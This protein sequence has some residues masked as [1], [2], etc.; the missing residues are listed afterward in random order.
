MNIRDIAQLANVSIS[1]VSKV[2][3]KKDESISAETREKILRIIK[4]YNYSPYANVRTPVKG[5]TLVLGVLINSASMQSS[6]IMGILRQSHEQG[7]GTLLYVSST[8][9]EEARNIHLLSSHNVDGIVRKKVPSDDKSSEAILTEMDIP[10]V[11]IGYDGAS[12]NAFRFDYHQLGKTCAAFLTEKHHSKI[13]CLLP[14]ESTRSLAF[15]EGV[16]EHMLSANTSYTGQVCHTLSDQTDLYSLL[17]NST[18]VV[19]MG[20]QIAEQVIAA[21][22]NLALHIPNDLSVVCLNCNAEQSISS[23]RISTIQLPFE[24]MGRYA[25]ASLIARLENR[26][27]IGRSFAL[28]PELNHHLSIEVPKVMRNK[29]IVVVGAINMDILINLDDFPQGEELVTARSRTKMPGG[30]GLNQ[31]VGAAKLGA[32]TYLIGRIGKD[33][34]GSLIYDFL[35]ANHVNMDGVILDEQ[36]NTGNAY[37]H[38]HKDGETSI[39]GYDGASNLLSGADID[40]KAHLF[41]DASYC[42]LQFV[43]VPD[44]DLVR[45]AIEVAREKHVKVILKPCKVHSID[46]SLL[47]HVDILLLKRKEID[48]LLPANISY[49]DKAQYFLDRGVKHV[50]I[51]LGHSG[52][53]LKDA[54]HSLYF[55]AANIVPVDTTGAGDAFAA[56]LAYY[57]S[58]NGDIVSAIRHANVAAGLSATRHGG[59]NSLVSKEDIELYLAQG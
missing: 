8:A 33:Y 17:C 10:W 44:P 54:E 43:C 30:K 32:D 20:M 58:D 27:E 45:R 25:T 7:Y 50:I 4:E 57:L 31:A 19:C 34:E 12:D 26:E 5:T 47:R 21:A 16:H 53:Y 15:G 56:T 46:E 59:S 13:I 42:I 18:A 24:E 41:H 37:V 9:E 48:R 29:K 52:C 40:A 51:T 14:D 39:I 28:E 49:E 6:S 22:D 36:H 55:D 38:I 2:I 3:N 35:C 1:T 23:S 11:S